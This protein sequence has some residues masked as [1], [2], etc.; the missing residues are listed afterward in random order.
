MKI[1]LNLATEPLVNNRPFYLASA[2]LSIA[3]LA[4]AAWLAGKSLDNY[5]STRAMRVKAA[6]LSTEIRTLDDEQRRIEGM[7]RRPDVARVFTRADF[8]NELIE[9]KSFSWTQVF[10]DLEKELPGGVHVSTIVPRQDAEGRVEVK[11]TVV[12]RDSA[13]LI[14][15]L[16]RLERSPAFHG[17]EVQSETASSGRP[18]EGIRVELT[19]GYRKS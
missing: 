15:L 12:A 13:S 10:M 16:R 17:V 19:A 1:S 2:L 8:L 4:A 11:L 3:A 9:L 18:G 7:L 6:Q 14:E 5:Q